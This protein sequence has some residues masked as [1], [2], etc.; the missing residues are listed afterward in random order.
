MP[1]ANEHVCAR[2]RA[3]ARA[4]AAGKRS[5]TGRM[6]HPATGVSRWVLKALS[7]LLC[8]S[9]HA[10]PLQ[11]Y[12]TVRLMLMMPRPSAPS[13]KSPLATHP[14]SSCP[15]ICPLHPNSPV[16]I[17]EAVHPMAVALATRIVAD[18]VAVVHA[19]RGSRAGAG[20]QGAT[21]CRDCAGVQVVDSTPHLRTRTYTHT[22]TLTHIHMC[23][24]ACARLL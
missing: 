13:T 7:R 14:P 10:Y 18:V 1:H 5:V 11:A 15:A 12:H 22:H 17:G 21:G 9:C 20:P 24:R 19:L 23:A 4:C 6:G 3:H 2:A 16:P 8:D